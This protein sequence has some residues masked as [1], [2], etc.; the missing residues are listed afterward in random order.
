MKYAFLTPIY[1]TISGRL[2]PQFLNLQDWCKDLDGRI[3]TIVGKTHV[4]ARNWLATDGGGFKN[5]AKLIDRVDYLVW[6]DADQKFNYQQLVTLLNADYPFCAGWYMNDLSGLAMVSDW[7][8]E[9]FEKNGTM[10]FYHMNEI[11]KKRKPF[12]V[13]YCGFGFTK[14][15][16]EILKQMEYPYFRQ[17]L[18]TIGKYKDNSSED[19]TFCLDVYDKTGIRPVI[20]PNLKID[21]LKE[22]F[23]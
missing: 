5:P 7:D 9:Y 13:A 12:E 23:I 22:V 1:N 18:T 17:R 15:S 6:I 14:V 4:N 16:T 21:H 2:L 11:I 20:L 19:T 10:K 8:K 3:Y